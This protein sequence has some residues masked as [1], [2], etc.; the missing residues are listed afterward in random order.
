MLVALSP[1]PP[2][3]FSI[4]HI[5]LKSWESAWGV[6][7]YINSTSILHALCSYNFSMSVYACMIEMPPNWQILVNTERY[8]YIFVI[9]ILYYRYLFVGSDVFSTST[10]GEVLW[11]DIRKLVEPVETLKLEYAGYMPGQK[12]GGIVMEYES[13]MVKT[14]FY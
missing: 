6:L 3:S 2:P 7:Y 14:K 11:W 4:L 12:L 10:D 13:T 9:I 1:G 5:A 8:R